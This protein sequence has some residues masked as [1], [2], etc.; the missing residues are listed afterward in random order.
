MTIKLV[1]SMSAPTVNTTIDCEVLM[2]M[3]ISQLREKVFTWMARRDVQDPDLMFKAIAVA[4]DM[5]LSDASQ[6]TDA[7]ARARGWVDVQTMHDRAVEMQAL[8]REF[9]FDPLGIERFSLTTSTPS[10][11]VVR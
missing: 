7:Q 1:S 5:S 2:F 6:M 3:P 8:C 9:G 4:A 10:L 11:D